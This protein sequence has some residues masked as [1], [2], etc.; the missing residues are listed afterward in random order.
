MGKEK[1]HVNVVGELFSLSSLIATHLIVDSYRPRRL[2]Q[3]HHYWP[4]DLQVRWY[5]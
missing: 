1:L 5:R 3:V 4:L 2:R